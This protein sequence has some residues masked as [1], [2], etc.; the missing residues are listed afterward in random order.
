MANTRTIYGPDGPQMDLAWAERRDRI[1]ELR[2]KGMLPRE[3]GPTVGMTENAVYQ[4][5]REAAEEVRD[6]MQERI[7]QRFMEHDARYEYMYRQ[8]QDKLSAAV[9]PDG[10]A[11]MTLSEYAGLLRAAV[12]I[13]ER[14]AKLLGLDR[15]P[16]GAGGQRKGDWLD[17]ATPKQLIDLAAKYGLDTPGKFVAEADAKHG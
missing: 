14:Q 11:L 6:R 13:L 16:G 1:V 10:V 7:E 17:S 3:I 9:S 15:N 12:A 2:A 8:V 5:L 4:V